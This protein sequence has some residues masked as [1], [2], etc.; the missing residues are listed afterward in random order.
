MDYT[1]S[2][3]FEIAGNTTVT[4]AM[5]TGKKDK[6]V[7]TKLDRSID[8]ITQLNRQSLKIGKCRLAELKAM[9]NYDRLRI[10]GITPA[11]AIKINFG[12]IPARNDVF[13][14]EKIFRI[15]AATAARWQRKNF[16]LYNGET[17]Y[18]FGDMIHQIYIDMQYYNYATDREVLR[19]LSRSCA[20]VNHGG[21]LHYE[22]YM[23]SAKAGKIISM[24]QDITGDGATLE[25]VL[26][27]DELH[28]N[29]EAMLEAEEERKDKARARSAERLE[30]LIKSQILGGFTRQKRE[31]LELAI[32]GGADI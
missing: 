30:A 21:I 20:L 9:Y 29:P 5:P 18:E 13:T 19:C 27:D 6:H 24:Q 3:L 15:I 11:Q 23:R 32:I 16:T 31:A 26:A 22:R 25:K 2:E 28:S 4:A 1:V 8:F 7:K 12:D 14:D 17:V 10:F